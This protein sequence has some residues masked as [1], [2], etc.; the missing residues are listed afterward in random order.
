MMRRIFLSLALLVVTAYLVMALTAFNR[1][2]ATVC[3]G[4]ELCL[5]DSDSRDFITSAEV[6]S[7]L[8]KAR[9]NPEGEPMASI[10]TEALE[11]ALSHHPLIDEVQ[12]YKTP[13]GRL[14]IE[15][16]QRIPLLQVM[17]AGG[18][19]YY[20]D[21]KGRSMPAGPQVSAHVAVATGHISPSLATGPLYEFALYLRHDPF[22]QAQ[23]EQ[24]HVTAA[25]G[26][27]L[28][29]R[30][31]RH[32]IYLGPLTGWEQKLHRAKRFYRQAIGRVGWDKYSRINVEF[33]NQIICTKK[34]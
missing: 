16:C 10:R 25:G 24:I 30:V 6:K 7:L 14:C 3:T 22:W 9:L 29:P 19:S 1:P 34:N 20:I 28:V 32:L 8:R 4:I 17:P 31:G 13:S 23:I 2:P 27:E 5:R 26:V 15:V 12:C 33:S 21:S 11:E 18:T